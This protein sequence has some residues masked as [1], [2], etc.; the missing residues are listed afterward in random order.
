[1]KRLRNFVFFLT[2]NLVVFAVFWEGAGHFLYRSE[3]GTWFFGRERRPAPAMPNAFDVKAAIFHPYFAYINRVGRSGDFG[4][5]LPDLW[6]TNNQGFQFA[7]KAIKD[8]CCDIPYAAKD[9]E[10]VVG[11]LGGSVGA[12]FG[13]MAGYLASF[14]EAVRAQP[15]FAGKRV[16][17]VNMAMSGYRQPQQAIVLAYYLTLGQRF[18][19]IVNIDGFNE[20][21]IPDYNV[22]NEAE[23]FFPAV[24]VWGAMGQDLESQRLSVA[25]PAV[26]LAAW[27]RQSIRAAEAALASCDWASCWLWWR[28]VTL[29]HRWRAAAT[30]VRNTT[31]DRDTTMFPMLMPQSKN[32]TPTKAWTASDSADGWARAA[33]LTAAVAMSGGAR[34]LHVLQPNQWYSAEPAFVP[35][36]PNHP[37]EQIVPLVRDGYP[38][39][40]A[41]VSTLIEAGVPVYDATSVYTGADPR[42]V[43]I[44]DC[45]HYTPEGYD[46][47]FRALA[48]PIATLR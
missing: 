4:P 15:A 16:R 11:I 33:R 19:L 48:A 12:G 18:D 17:V 30:A 47:L 34:Y 3:T 7:R 23:P 13:I 29:I 26:L 38:A 24:Q 6:T 21:V 1:M 27:H 10:V 32:A 46:V 8:G 36:D 28:V 31:V 44:D 40:R 9:D 37:F 41:R 42:A 45:C 22:R 14:E 5:E 20:L 43:F 35:R 39:L 2:L 25:E